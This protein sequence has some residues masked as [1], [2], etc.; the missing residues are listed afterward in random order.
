VTEPLCVGRRG[1]W[2][3]AAGRTDRQG[4]EVSWPGSS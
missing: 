4:P 1:N 3:E 2:T